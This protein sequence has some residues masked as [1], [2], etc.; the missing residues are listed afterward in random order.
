MEELSFVIVSSV[1]KWIE[2]VSKQ[3]GVSEKGK[4]M[5]GYKEDS[6]CHQMWNVGEKVT[7]SSKLKTSKLFKSKM[8]SC[9]LRQKDEG[10]D[11]LNI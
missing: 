2:L 8:I 11:Q 5:F 1:R 3:N 6:E 9:W 7:T 4:R 10:T